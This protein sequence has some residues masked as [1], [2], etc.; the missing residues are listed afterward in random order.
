MKITS[1]FVHRPTLVFVLLALISLA[2]VM[3]WQSLPQQQFPNVV[4]PTISINASFSGA[5]TTVMRDSVVA[6][7]EDLLAG[8]PDLTLLNSVV[9]YGTARISATF[10]INSNINTDLVNV[11]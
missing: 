4:R 7:I 6:P 8:T 10:D 2:G 11:Q 1:L 9:Q 5:S 3:A